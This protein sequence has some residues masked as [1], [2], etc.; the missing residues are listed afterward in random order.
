MN[1]RKFIELLNLYVDGE[2]DPEG[3]RRL[4]QMI[5]RD[6][7]AQRIYNQYCR[8]HRGSRLIYERFR[9]HAPPEKI[10]DRSRTGVLGWFPAARS[11]RLA[12][13]ASGMAAAI[14]L[15]TG[16]VLLM[17]PGGGREI[18]EEIAL[19]P[20]Q[21]TGSTSV[22]AVPPMIQSFN[23]DTDTFVLVPSS[24][25]T[26]VPAAWNPEISLRGEFLNQRVAPVAWPAFDGIRWDT[27]P[28][29]TYPESVSLQGEYRVYRGLPS[30]N[31]RTSAYQTAGFQF[32]K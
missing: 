23:A 24:D 11:G 15:V 32:Q 27:P 1:R 2:I 25:G 18:M 21:G 17:Q 8:L 31:H 3:V 20:V 28:R 13:V 30:G 26:L 10:P 16:S 6:A 7:E 29:I 14:V 4:E 19:N 5:S 12:I 22:V 9:M